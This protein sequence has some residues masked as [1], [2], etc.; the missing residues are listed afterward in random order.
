MNEFKFGD[1]KN[2]RLDKIEMSNDITKTATNSNTVKKNERIKAKI[3][4]I[5]TMTGK[6][7]EAVV[8]INHL[9]HRNVILENLMVRYVEEEKDEIP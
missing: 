8:F 5:S 9:H 4:S 2:N 7:V 6:F 3:Q 1:L